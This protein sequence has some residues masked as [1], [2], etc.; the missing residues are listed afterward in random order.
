MDYMNL[1][2]IEGTI[3]VDNTNKTAYGN[4]AAQLKSIVGDNEY[5]V[6]LPIQQY[7]PDGMFRVNDVYDEITKQQVIKRIDKYVINND[8]Q[9]KWEDLKTEDIKGA[10][11][12]FYKAT[13][14]FTIPMTSGQ[15]PNILIPG[16]TTNSCAPADLGDKECTLVSGKYLYIHDTSIKNS[17][18]VKKNISKYMYYE[19]PEPVILEN[20]DPTIF[21]E[22]IAASEPVLEPIYTDTNPHANYHAKVKHNKS[23]NGNT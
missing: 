20:F 4:T 11:K 16:Y 13:L 14:S 18:E 21:I 7:F 6:D 3:T 17:G 19:L 2:T 23:K 12:F 9:L 22:F 5:I 15:L 1:E 10:I 8:K